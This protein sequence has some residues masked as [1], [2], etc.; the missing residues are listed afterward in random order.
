MK[1]QIVRGK[2]VRVKKNVITVYNP[3]ELARILI[4]TMIMAKTFEL[5]RKIVKGDSNEK[6]V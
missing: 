2:V 3:N 6:G 4:E 1:K 5:G